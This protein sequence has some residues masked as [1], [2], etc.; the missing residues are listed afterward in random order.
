MQN[1]IDGVEQT[2]SVSG[3]EL[4]YG[5]SFA[6]SIPPNYDTTDR[7]YIL[8][9]QCPR[10]TDGYVIPQPETTSPD[11]SGQLS[12]IQTGIDA[13]TTLLQQILAKLDLIYQKMQG[14]LNPSLDSAQTIPHDLQQYYSGIASGAP[15]ASAIN[16]YSGGASLIPFSS[17]LSASG[18]GGL[19]GLLVGIACAGWV[20]TRGRGLKYDRLAR[21]HLYNLFPHR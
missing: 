5:Y 16:N 17:I 12:D 19:F 11:Y 20:L 6:Y 2:F 9:V 13:N 15:S 7:Y 21:K 10:V 18:L 1:I 8:L 3:Q 14:E 4:H